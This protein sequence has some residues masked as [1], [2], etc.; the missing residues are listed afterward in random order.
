MTT[1]AGRSGACVLEWRRARRVCV[2]TGARCTRT[3][4]CM[5]YVKPLHV[6]NTH[7]P[8]SSTNFYL[9]NR[10]PIPSS[11]HRTDAHTHALAST[12]RFRTRRASR[13]ISSASSSP[14]SSSRTAA[15]SRTT[16]FRKSRRS[17]SCSA[18]AVATGVSSVM[19]PVLACPRAAS[20]SAHF[21]KYVVLNTYH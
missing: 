16:T 10:P 5:K 13:R 18:C 11:P 1:T 12:Y 7:S 3:C 21:G 8:R 14:A 15:P 2:R 19:L 9:H 20:P 4:P 6:S 17:T